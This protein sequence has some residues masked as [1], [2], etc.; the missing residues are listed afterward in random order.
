MFLVDIGDIDPSVAT[1]FAC[2]GVTVYSALKKAQPVQDD[3]WLVIMGAGG[4]GPAAVGI[5]R[6]MGFKQILSCDI[7]DVKLS[8][9]KDMGA[10]AALNISG[11]EAAKALAADNRRRSSCGYRY[12]RC[13]PDGTTRLYIPP[14]GRTIRD[15]R[16]LWR[17]NNRP[18]AN[19][20]AARCLNY[21]LLCRKSEGP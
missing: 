9:A 11:D 17:R 4:L 20:A 19:P 8:A 7:D 3:E 2:S 5:A 13:K 18:S 10:T 15:C 16:P 1:P 21:R 14:Q 12:G 6:A